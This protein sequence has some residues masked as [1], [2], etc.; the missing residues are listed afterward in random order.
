MSSRAG[1]LA[2]RSARPTRATAEVPSATTR[3]AP[4]VPAGSGERP[5]ADVA[6]SGADSAGSCLRI[7]FSSVLNHGL[8]SIPS[9]S[10]SASR[11]TRYAASASAWRPVR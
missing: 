11:V 7:A 6:D 2:S 8:G 1:R 10:T 9:A 4:S 3:I 5:G